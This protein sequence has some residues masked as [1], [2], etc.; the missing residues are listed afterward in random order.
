[1]RIVP[2]M[3]SQ[4]ERLPEIKPATASIDT[5]TTAVMR[6]PRVPSPRPPMA[7]VVIRVRTVNTTLGLP[8]VMPSSAGRNGGTRI[9]P[10]RPHHSIQSCSDQTM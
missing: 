6:A 10:T 8:Q 1:M 3:A 4:P 9:S 7:T 2:E 5:S